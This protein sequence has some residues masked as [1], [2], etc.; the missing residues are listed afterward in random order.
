MSTATG[1][2]PTSLD[3]LQSIATTLLALLVIN[4]AVALLV[5]AQFDGY[6]RVA[7]LGKLLGVVA[8]G[9]LVAQVL[10]MVRGESA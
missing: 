3:D 6:T 1:P 8:V 4:L 5:L 9:V 7:V 2:L 10:A